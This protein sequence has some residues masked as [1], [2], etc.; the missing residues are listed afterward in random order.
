M[1][2][3]Q[4]GYSFIIA[5]TASESLFWKRRVIY[6]LRDLWICF[7]VDSRKNCLNSRIIRTASGADANGEMLSPAVDG[8]WFPQDQLGQSD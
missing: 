3:F 6:A 8:N 7:A 2:H 1:S 5:A 4:T